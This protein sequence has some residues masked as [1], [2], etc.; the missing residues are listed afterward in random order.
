MAAHRVS[1]VFRKGRFLTLENALLTHILA[2]HCFQLLGATRAPINNEHF[3]IHKAEWNPP[4]PRLPLGGFI[5]A[6]ARI[7]CRYPTALK[8]NNIDLCSLGGNQRNEGMLNRPEQN[9]EHFLH[10]TAG[11]AGNLPASIIC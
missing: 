7:V 2:L 10:S 3:D 4:P 11:V 1:T 5:L 9:S 6:L 8:G